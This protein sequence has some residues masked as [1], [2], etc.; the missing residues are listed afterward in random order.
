MADIFLDEEAHLFE[1]LS[2][3]SDS[4]YFFISNMKKNVA[5]WSNPAQE[6]FGL[7]EK[8]IENI[9]EFWT[10]RVHP[11][12]QE[13]F[14][15][16]FDSVLLAHAHHHNLEYRVLTA[17]G[18]YEWILCSSYIYYDEQGIP[19]HA[20]GFVRPL[21]YRNKIDPV[22]NLRTI[23]EFRDNLKKRLS[24]NDRGSILMFDLIN[25]KKVIDDH[26]YSF[27]DKFL[28]TM[29]VL[30]KQELGKEDSIF[31]MQGSSFAVVI[32]SC[33]KSDIQTAYEA[34]KKVLRCVSV[35]GI[36]ID[37]DFVCAATIFP[38]DGVDIDRLQQNL[39]YGID[40]AKVYS[41]KDLVYYTDDLYLQ[42]ARISQ[43]REA[44]KK[45]LQNNFAGFELYFQP[46]IKAG[47][48]TCDSAEALLRF[49]TPELGMVSPV[50][51]I[52]LLEKTQDIVIVGAWV[53]D[54]A[55][56]FL[57]KWK[58]INPNFKQI[59]VNVSSVQFHDSSFKDY[60]FDTLHKHHLPGEALVL[61]LTESCRVKSTQEFSKL[62]SE[63]QNAGVKMALDDFGTGYASMIVLCD[64]PVDILKIDY[65]LTQNFV[66]H[67]QHRT[68]LKLVVDLCKNGNIHLCAEGVE[69]QESLELMQNAGAE[70]IQGYFFSKPLSSEEFQ[71]KFIQKSE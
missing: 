6:F 57:E 23:H 56:E 52:P 63:F 60:V 50:D 9:R 25:F 69:N 10:S 14:N 48:N 33:K 32:K 38:S 37:Q 19:D 20:A 4:A 67:P 59:H 71:K 65:Q 51:F 54:K 53:L 34:I 29:G 39:Y 31:R 27:G 45:S 47:K 35:E 3:S 1:A 40:F 66:K 43:L 5:L 44:I 22:S 21:G 12:D 8:R 41:L 30:L 68:I 17:E 11:D 62:F 16:Y 55:M 58:K 7:K 61:E 36:D 28:Y 15:T 46:I 18:K 49:S 13:K 2:N 70:L 42:K 26:G 64:I 24:K